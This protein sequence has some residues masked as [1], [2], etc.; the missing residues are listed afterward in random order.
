MNLV[1]TTGYPSYLVAGLWAQVN[2]DP[3]TVQLVWYWWFIC[4]ALGKNWKDPFVC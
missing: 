1:S 4:L 3:H 2:E